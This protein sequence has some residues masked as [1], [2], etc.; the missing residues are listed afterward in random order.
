MIL[1]S[2]PR[3]NFFFFPHPKYYLLYTSPYIS[4]FSST[5]FFGFYFSVLN[6]DESS[7]FHILI[8]HKIVKIKNFMFTLIY[9]KTD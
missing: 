1:H 9:Q 5:D 6:L 4:T 3:N 7:L 8:L 2:Y